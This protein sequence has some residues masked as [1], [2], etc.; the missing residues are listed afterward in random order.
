[1][2]RRTAADAQPGKVHGRV[3][4]NEHI[5]A[6]GVVHVRQQIDA[7]KGHVLKVELEDDSAAAL[8]KPRLPQHG[9]DRLA[10]EPRGRIAVAEAEG[11][12]VIYQGEGTT[13]LAPRRTW[14]ARLAQTLRSIPPLPWGEGR[15]EGNGV[16]D[17]AVAPERLRWL[18]TLAEAP[19]G[20]RSF[21]AGGLGL[22]MGLA[23]GV[24]SAVATKTFGARLDDPTRR[25]PVRPPGSVPEKEFL[26]LCIRCGECFKV[27]PNSVLQPLVFQQGLEGL[28]TPYVAA[29]WAGCEPSCNACGQACPAGA[30]RALPLEE[31]KVARMALAV[32][33]EETC[34]PWAGREAC[35]LCVDE[36]AAAGYDAIEFI[37]VHTKADNSGKPVA[38]TG[39]LAPK[40]QPDKCV[41][42]GL[43]Q[44]RCYSI[45]AKTKNLVPESAIIVEAGD[46][47]EDRMMS[48]SYLALRK[49]ETQPESSRPPNPVQPQGY[50]P[51]FLERP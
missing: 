28:W 29:D 32:V 4:L 35:Q 14:R 22:L 10:P 3:I 12:G 50:L 21:A 20:R 46:G 51:E 17:W 25:R 41:G 31:K 19:I 15:G 11:D 16:Q 1:N 34:L 45:N 2:K 24:G 30:I 13:H 48:G 26:E 49:R 23:G 6:G 43:C 33:N 44:M 39:F 37:R 18:Q 9:A 27:C 42:C 8:D 40:V 36:C 5:Q 47:K 7:A 38:G